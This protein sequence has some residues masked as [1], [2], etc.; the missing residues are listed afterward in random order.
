M[1][2][3]Q[4]PAPSVRARKKAVKEKLAARL[5]LPVLDP[6]KLARLR[7]PRRRSKTIVELADELATFKAVSDAVRRSDRYYF[8]ALAKVYGVWADLLMVDDAHRNEMIVKLNNR[9]KEKTKRGDAIHVLLRALI[10]YRVK[11]AKGISR[12]E[13]ARARQATWTR[14][15][16]DAS[17]LRFAEREEVPVD[18][19]VDFVKA[20]PGGLEGMARDEARARRASASTATARPKLQTKSLTKPLPARPLT[21]D[22]AEP[23]GDSSGGKG[24]WRLGPALRKKLATGMFA[25]RE[26]IVRVYVGSDGRRTV[27]DVYQSSNP[28]IDDA[29]WVR[30]MEGL[31]ARLVGKGPKRPKV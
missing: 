9:N 11:D 19:F 26:L 17:V 23:S 18:D 5:E 15:S 21:P 7:S 10:D 6:D 1:P 28:A 27:R 13:A 31:G 29:Q 4:Q 12:E 20:R 24:R 16:R 22:S 30:D 14:L 2:L 25:G 8:S 3:K